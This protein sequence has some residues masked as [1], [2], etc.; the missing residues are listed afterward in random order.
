[1]T[2]LATATSAF[3]RDR[4]FFIHDGAKLRRIRLSAPFQAA[5]FVVLL[6]LVGWSSYATARFISAGANAP[7]G[8]SSLAEATEARARQIEQRQALIEAMLLGGDVDPAVLQQAASGDLA[9]A[10]GGPLARIE[11]Q[12][13]LQAALAARALDARYEHTAAELKRLGF[14]LPKPGQDGMG[15]PSDSGDPTFK[16]LFM[17]WK[18]LDSITDTAI[19]VPADKPVR[20]AAF[21]SGYGMRTDPVDGQGHRLHAG[22]DLAGPVGTPIYATADGTVLRSGWNSGGYGN[23]VELDHGKSIATRYG[24]LSSI[25]VQPGQRVRRGQV[26]GRMGS[27]GRSTGSHLHYEVRIDGRAVNPIP[28][29]KATDYLVAMRTRAGAAP[30]D[31]VAMGGPG[32]GK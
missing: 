28:F 17:S 31:A 19:A 14:T 4:D 2:Q 7:A 5:L 18:K 26:I 30:M 20:T 9:H 29:M 32:G 13:M 8:I 16:Q 22:I 1:M 25:S 27:T 12:Q 11:N 15:G 3:F 24:H 10:A 23:L 21:T 6:A